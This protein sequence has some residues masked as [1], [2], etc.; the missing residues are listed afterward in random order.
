LKRFPARFQL[1][2]A[3]KMP[4][5]PFPILQ[6]TYTFT[7]ELNNQH[8]QPANLPFIAA[9]QDFRSFENFGSLARKDPSPRRIV[10]VTG[11][12]ISPNHSN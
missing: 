3:Q 4:P 2:L 8:M 12:S 11:L 6:K 10:G 5:V 9:A 1:P 7:P